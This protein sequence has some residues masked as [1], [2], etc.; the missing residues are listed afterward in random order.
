MYPISHQCNRSK[1]IPVA[2]HRT[3]DFPRIIVKQ[4][5]KRIQ[6]RNLLRNRWLRRIR[7]TRLLPFSVITND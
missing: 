1:L 6:V 7:N 3:N 5:P 4:P 2:I